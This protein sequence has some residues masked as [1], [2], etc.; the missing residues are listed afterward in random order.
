[1]YVNSKDSNGR[2]RG[3]FE[4]MGEEHGIPQYINT[5]KDVLFFDIDNDTDLDVWFGN[6]GE[7]DWL[8]INTTLTPG[9]M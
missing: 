6:F 2:C 4:P 8:L 1:M 7:V 3:I 9:T 5:T